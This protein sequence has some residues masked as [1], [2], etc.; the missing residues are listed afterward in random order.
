M[1]S[2]R[3]SPFRP[4]WPHMQPRHRSSEHRKHRYPALGSRGGGR[5]RR[6]WRRTGGSALL[7][8]CRC[9]ALCWCSC[10]ARFGGGGVALCRIIVYIPA[11]AFEVQSRRGKRAFEYALA[12]WAHKLLLGAE[13]LDLLKA[14]TALGAPVRIQ[15][16]SS[17]PPE[18]T[19]HFTYCIGRAANSLQIAAL[20]HP[21]FLNLNARRSAQMPNGSPMQA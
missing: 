18:R 14:V 5:S 3:R 9:F 13:V 17:H 7:G 6:R 4:N 10:R 11:G 15:R 1:P 21:F 19:T 8:G 20:S 2:S 12:H 16:Q